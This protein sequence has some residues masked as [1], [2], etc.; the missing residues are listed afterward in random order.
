MTWPLLGRMWS[1]DGT[2]IV[3]SACL[4]VF[5]GYVYRVTPDLNGPRFSDERSHAV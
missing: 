5:W 3:S 2:L 4:T 1:A